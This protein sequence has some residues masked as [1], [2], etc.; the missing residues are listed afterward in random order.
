MA[1]VAVGLG[2]IVPVLQ[3]GDGLDGMVGIYLLARGRQ[4]L[5]GHVYLLKRHAHP[6]GPS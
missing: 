6:A 4:D 2:M 5:I 3:I 1:V